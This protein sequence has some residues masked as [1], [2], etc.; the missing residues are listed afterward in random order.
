MKRYKKVTYD[1]ISK[2]DL[3]EVSMADGTW[4]RAKITRKT[5]RAS[6]FYPNGAVHIMLLPSPGQSSAYDAIGVKQLAKYVRVEVP[7]APSLPNYTRVDLLNA[8]PQQFCET[9]FLASKIGVTDGFSDRDELRSEFE[10]V[11]LLCE[12]NKYYYEHMRA[13][14]EAYESGALYVELMN[15]PPTGR[16]RAHTACAGT[17]G[18]V[19]CSA[20]KDRQDEERR[21][22]WRSGVTENGSYRVRVTRG[23]SK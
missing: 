6:R 10:L 21:A 7:D 9:L 4:C 3:V 23:G 19:T 8:S 18:T 15:K 1:E 16:A 12:P 13:L 14:H 17:C 20:E 22:G 5:R 2:G 11:Q